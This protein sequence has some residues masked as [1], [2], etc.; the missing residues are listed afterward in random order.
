M[1]RE[2]TSAGED[3]QERAELDLGLGQFRGRVGVADDSHSRVET[4]FGASEQSAPEGDAELAVVVGVG[5]ADRS[6]VPASVDAFQRRDE[7]DGGRMRLAADRRGWVEQTGELDGA[8]RVGELGSDRGGEVLDVRDLDQ[9]RFVRGGDPDGVVSQ[10]AG[11]AADD[12]RV[13]FAVLLRPQLPLAEVVVDR[14]VGGTAGGAGQ[15]HRLGSVTVS[16]DQQ[17]G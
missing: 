10:G 13:F 11:D 17:L 9:G 12:D 8:D 3:R 5:P 16:A 15:S 14:R 1:V 6:R 2:L 4:R 7:R